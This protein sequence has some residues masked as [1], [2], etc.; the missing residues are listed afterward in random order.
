MLNNTY[1]SGIKGKKLEDY[2]ALI[3]QKDIKDTYTFGEPKLSYDV[4]E[5][6]ADFVLTLQSKKNV[7]IEIGF[8]KEEIEQ[9]KNTMKKVK[10]PL[11]GLVIGS[12]KLELINN[13]IVKVP[14]RFLMLI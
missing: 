4:A 6:G 11:Y 2:F 12:K 3:F 1:P 10:N 7:V 5:N 8:N 14:L 13:S 9:V